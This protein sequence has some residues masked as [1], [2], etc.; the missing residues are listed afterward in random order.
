MKKVQVV[1]V[2]SL[3]FLFEVC[4][5]QEITLQVAVISKEAP[6]QVLMQEEEGIQSIAFQRSQTDGPYWGRVARPK[7]DAL[8][9]AKKLSLAY[10]LVASWADGKEQLFLK[11]QSH[12]P[13]LIALKLYHDQDAFNDVALNKIDGLGTDL[14]SLIEKYCRARAFHM[15]WRFVKN[16]P[17][18]FIA[19]RSARVWFDTAVALA[20]R[21]NS[22]FRMDGDIMKIMN[23]YEAI[24]LQN[25]KF[26]SRYRKYV[27]SG[28][29]QGILDD[30]KT[31]EYAFVGLVPRL[32]AE[33]KHQEAYELNLKAYGVLSGESESTRKLVEKRQGVNLE[34]LRRN[35][36][37]LAPKA[38]L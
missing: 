38:G 36:A 20:I 31:A 6:A 30:V 26:N 22:P 12:L 9:D 28:Y 10:R 15:H 1:A 32:V 3:L 37:F 18:N 19:L 4:I 2:L 8:A 17:E 13:E 24:A 21:P 29:V 16:Q 23:D 25:N 35:A 27:P 34:L 7:T 33:G 14:D 11:I 5:A